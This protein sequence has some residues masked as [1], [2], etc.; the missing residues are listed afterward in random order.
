MILADIILSI[1][2]ILLIVGGLVRNVLSLRVL[3]SV[4]GGFAV[5]YGLAKDD[6]NLTLWEA[7]FTLV[8]AVQGAIL[9]REKRGVRLSTEERELHQTRFSQM[10]LI[11]FHRFV[12]AGTWVSAP[13]DT[14]LTRQGQPVVRIVLLSEGAVSVTINGT[15]VAYCKRGDF[16]GEMA[17]VS[18][19]PASATVVTIGASRYLMWN[20]DDLRLLIER[21]PDIKT[22]LQ[23]VFTQNLIEK[24][25]RPDAASQRLST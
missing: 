12:R 2:Y 4:A 8:N 1:S 5:W 14:E 24:I 11:D 16:V 23:G 22:A 17:F 9:W 18:G 6:L 25:G 15:I 19:N 13:A 21:H 3:F 20:F 7:G 10:S